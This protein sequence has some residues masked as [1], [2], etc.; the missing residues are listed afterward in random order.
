MAS[1][2][3]TAQQAVIL[4]LRKLGVVTRRTPPKPD[5]IQD[6]LDAL[7]LL[8]ESFNTQSALIPFYTKYTFGISTTKRLYTIGP[9]GDFD[10]PVPIDILSAQLIDAGGTYHRVRVVDGI[11]YFQNHNQNMDNNVS[12]PTQVIWNPSI[13]TG[14]LEFSC[15]PSEGDTLALAVKLPWTVEN[16]ASA[17]D[18]TNVGQ[19]VNAD[20]YTITIDEDSEIYCDD[21][22]QLNVT[23]QMID[24]LGEQASTADP[25]NYERTFKY[26]GLDVTAIASL[27]ARTAPNPV[28][29]SIQKDMEFPVGY[30]PLIMWSLAEAM[31]PEYPQ[32]NPSTISEIKMQASKLLRN[33]KAKNARP[34]KVQL[35]RSLLSN[36]YRLQTYRRS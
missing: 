29:L 13:P 17:Q 5:D 28:Q 25:V 15:V 2:G 4:A 19:P 12:R 1:P 30:L 14:T 34:G 24:W 32:E 35:D 16:Y 7:W 8:L 33:I 18:T 10:M 36:Q 9:G 21:E 20:D 22:C 6:G 26:N 27:E 31:L 23:Q 3:A 11:Q